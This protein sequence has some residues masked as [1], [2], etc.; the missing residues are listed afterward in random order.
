MSL[1]M[2]A[3]RRAESNKLEATRN[4]GGKEAPTPQDDLT[5]EPLNRGPSKLNA[6]PLPDLA[7]HIDAVDAELTHTA[8]ATTAFKPSS[9]G[10]LQNTEQHKATTDQA[11][12]RNA[13]AVKS[14]D[15]PDKLVFKM[16]LLGLAVVATGIAGYFAYQVTNLSGQ[17]LATSPAV[18]TP[19][20]LTGAS[21]APIPAESL[22][23][24]TATTTQ[25]HDLQDAEISTPA[26]PTRTT[27]ALLQ[28]P[29][30][31]PPIRLTRSKPEVDPLQLRGYAHIERMELDLAK[32]DYEQSLLRDPNNINSLIA[33]GSIAQHQGRQTE[34]E[35]FFQRAIT[36][37]PADPIAQAALL[38]GSASKIDP[39]TAESRIKTLLANQPES[40][41]LNFALGNLYARQGRWGEAQQHYF[42]AVAGEAD[43]PDYLF[44]LAVS[45]DQ[46]RQERLAANHYKLALEAAQKRPSAFDPIEVRKRLNQLQP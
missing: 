16:I 31:D 6:N 38:N 18:S 12:I 19:S 45:L 4:V 14:N 9:T 7:E 15:E 20:P 34:A 33:L 1:L 43:N 41:P 25:P 36:S 21:S 32:R 40:A 39:Q 23:T 10:P 30:N 29:A 13:F 5:L 24:S 22:P 42:N 17:S 8:S 37:N 27:S 11:A 46:I 3:L 35:Q 28:A 44:N 2:D 26:Y